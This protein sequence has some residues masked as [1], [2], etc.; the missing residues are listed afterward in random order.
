MFPMQ[1]ELEKDQKEV[2]KS[3]KVQL[4]TK[5]QV[6]VKICNKTCQRTPLTFYT[7]G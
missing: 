1:W 7:S 5:R 6:G 3:E 2:D 4:L